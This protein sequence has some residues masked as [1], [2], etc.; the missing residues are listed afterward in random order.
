MRVG[1]ETGLAVLGPMGGG[2][3]VEYGAMGDLLNTAARLQAKADPGGVLVGARDL[4]PDLGP[5]R[6]RP[7]R[8]L[9]LKG[10][11]GRVLA[12]PVL[13]ELERSAGARPCSGLE[14]PLVGRERELGLGRDAL[15]EL[16]GGGGGVLL[17]S[18]EAGL[19]KTRL[20]GELRRAAGGA[21]RAGLEGRCVSYG[22]SLPYWPFQGV[23]RDWL[24]RGPSAE[25]LRGALGAECARLLGDRAGEVEEPL[26]IL[27][28]LE[29]AEPAG[30]SGPELLQ[31]RIHSSFIA[32]LRALAAE[33]PLVVALDDLHWADPSSIALLE[34]ALELTGESQLLL[35]LSGRPDPE[36]PFDRLRARMSADGGES[37]RAI[38]LHALGEDAEQ[39]LL[40]GLIGSGTLPAR[41]EAQLLERAE[42]N[43]FYLEE[44]VRSMVDAGALVRTPTG[45]RFESEV[46]VEVPDTVE[47]VVLARVDRLPAQTQEVLRAGAVLGR[48]FSLG[49]V[50]RVLG[51]VGAAGALADLEAADLLRDAGRSP[52]PPSA[53]STR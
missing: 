30:A 26:A 25:G 47:K 28:G 34:R 45:W 18:G 33:T 53:S 39:G 24:G 9:E 46:P 7:A 3:R 14:A 11:A 19:G 49:L 1:I 10:K 4:P 15:T 51:G 22:E 6:V 27:L 23:L 2:D 44:L 50:E 5:L 41:L 35:V 8:E 17:L 16:A 48:R 36:H 43:P 40:A 32:L 20:L 37:F 13:A 29:G 52:S 42:G 21:A 38:E 31:E 12:Y